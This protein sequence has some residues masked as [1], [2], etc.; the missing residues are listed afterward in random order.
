MSSGLESAILPV[1]ILVSKKTSQELF[2]TAFFF[3]CP[4]EL[5]VENVSNATQLEIDQELVEIVVHDDFSFLSVDLVVEIESVVA[6]DDA[7]VITGNISQD[8]PF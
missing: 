6:F 7:K 3:Q 8:H 1:L 4:F 2:V 5:T